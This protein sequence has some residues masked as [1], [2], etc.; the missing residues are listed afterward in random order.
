MWYP[1][2]PEGK[3]GI[4]VCEHPGNWINP[5]T[6][7]LIAVFEREEDRDFVLQLHAREVTR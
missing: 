2:I 5:P 4:T 1:C 6:W 7:K 3:P